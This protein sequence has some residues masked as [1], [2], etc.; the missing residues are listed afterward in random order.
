MLF[1]TCTSPLWEKDVVCRCTVLWKNAKQK[2]TL[3]LTHVELPNSWVCV[4]DFALP[5]LCL[6]SGQCFFGI[7]VINP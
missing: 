2:K 3:L 5:T 6:K 1:V 4:T 7:K